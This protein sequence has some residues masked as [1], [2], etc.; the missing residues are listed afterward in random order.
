MMAHVAFIATRRDRG[1]WPS[2]RH[3]VIM[4]LPRPV[5]IIALTGRGKHEQH[6]REFRGITSLAP[7]R[8]SR[9]IVSGR[10]PTGAAISTGAAPCGG[11]AGG[12]PA[13]AKA[14]TG[15]G[16]STGARGLGRSACRGVGARGLARAFIRVVCRTRA[17]RIGPAHVIG[18]RRRRAAF[19]LGPLLIALVRSG[20]RGR[21]GPGAG[22]GG[23][24]PPPGGRVRGG[25]IKGSASI[26]PFLTLRPCGKGGTARPVGEGGATRPR[27]S[28]GPFTAVASPPGRRARWATPAR[29]ASR[30]RRGVGPSRRAGIIK[31]RASPSRRRT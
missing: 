6:E 26:R 5:G 11:I 28:R 12:G 8:G 21:R 18:G 4:L 23:K 15:G 2:S 3:A 30:G 27:W 9:P 13:L 22:R 20:G 19:R 14:P 17:P 31:G 29:R 25:I 10:G 16:T 24:G 7:T 1:T